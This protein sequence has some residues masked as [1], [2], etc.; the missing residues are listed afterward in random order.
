[1][2][3]RNQEGQA[4]GAV[5]Y[6]IV[7]YGGGAHALRAMREQTAPL[8][9]LTFPGAVDRFAAWTSALH[10]RSA[11]LFEARTSQLRY[12]RTALHC[13]R[14]SLDHYQ[15][16]ISLRGDSQISSG[17]REIA[18]GPGDIGIL[19]MALTNRTL[20]VP[21]SDADHAHYVTLTLPRALL[22]PL[23]AAP[24]A[25]GCRL[26]RGD[27][28]YGRILRG[29]ILGLW[30]NGRDL[31]FAEADPITRSV[32]TLV[33]GALHPAPGSEPQVAHVETVA[34]RAAIKSRL[35]QPRD[36]SGDLDVDSLCRAFGISRASLY[37]MFEPEGGLVHYARG[38][39]LQRALAV[40]TSPAHR[41]RRILD[42]AL[43]HGFHTES[44]FARAFRRAFGITPAEARTGDAANIHGK[45]SPGVAA[46]VVAAR[47]SL[48]WILGLGPAASVVAPTPRPT[49]AG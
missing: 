34:K 47:D 18:I 16:T 28:A 4:H 40:I 27:T 45:V 24:D 41:H 6:D 12:D 29:A 9:D 48:S 8:C 43:Q 44:G 42:I 37:R 7:N 21:P 49:S 25:V 31:S 2:R 22:A 46:G 39:Q 32:A 19:D 3:V 26:I 5:P 33:A 14:S 17:S 11:I 10:L 23:L 35:E 1:M 15:A 30:R 20:I 38:R 13:A 36:A